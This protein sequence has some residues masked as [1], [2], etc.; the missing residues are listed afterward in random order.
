M[1][2]KILPQY[3]LF[4]ILDF[5]LLAAFI[6]AGENR[7]SNNRRAEL[8]KPAAIEEAVID[9]G[10]VHCYFSN[11]TFATWGD[12]YQ[13]FFIGR[14][15]LAEPSMM[16]LEGG[17]PENHY[18]FF[19][20]S[21]IVLDQ[22]MVR[23]N[24]LT[25]DDWIVRINDPEAKS[26]YEIS[27][28]MTDEVAG[29]RKKGIKVI[30]TVNGW[31]ESY[32]DDFFILEYDII[33]TG[34]NRFFDCYFSFH[35][36]ADIST[37]ERGTGPE[38]YSR[39]DLVSYYLGTDQDG[40]PEHISY[41]Y[42]GDNSAYPGDD[43]GG[44]DEPKESLGFIGSRVLECPPRIEEGPE[45][46]NTQSGHQWW[47]W[48]SDPILDDF[49]IRCSLQEFKDDPGSPHDYRYLQSVGPF[50]LNPGDTA[51]VALA[52]GI[53]EGL[54]G[55]RENLQWA[56]DL[57]W[58]DF[59]GPAAPEAPLTEIDSGDRWVKITWDGEGSE[60]SK[61]PM[62]G[63]KD[64][65]GYRLYRSLDKT[66]WSL[67]ANYDIV[68]DILE[69]T[70]LP[71]KNE[72]GLYEFMDRDVMNGFVYYYSVTAYD[73]GSEDM[74]SWETGKQ[75]D[76][77]AQPGTKLIGNAID[78][79]KIRV[80]PNPFVVKAPWDFTPTPDNPSEERLQ[81]QNVPKGAKVTIFTLTGDLIIELYQQGDQGWIDWDLITKN[82]QKVVSGLYLY[83]VEAVEGENF[84]G[85]FVIVR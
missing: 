3:F 34:P 63:E 82:R 18:L 37:A 12:D 22:S 78:E 20:F 70:G 55:L 10:A 84:I 49:Y 80:V 45:S 54:E 24:S 9:I 58:N 4:I 7:D 56:Y 5:I 21:R 61:D 60:N 41:M 69:N 27:F 1:K 8:V 25:C 40:N 77:F 33:N 16:W 83:A 31:P 81:F 74:P 23:F 13:T 72:Y 11:R 57:Y 30:Q 35:A 52:F 79:N 28:S 26:P 14:D 47:D 67:L 32:R 62:T 42:D 17:Y 73:K 64:F 44:K 76:L 29:N 6:N 38:A 48:N 19:G 85:K 15:D 50:V 66:D 75:N 51:H 39:D 46:A 2:I 53:G 36:D 68:N 71:V 59:L 65:E 43:T